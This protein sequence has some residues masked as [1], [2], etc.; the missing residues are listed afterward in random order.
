MNK[1]LFSIVTAAALSYL[2]PAAAQSTAVYKFPSTDPAVL[3]YAAPRSVVNVRITVE[4][5]S[6]RSGPYARY[7]QRMLG[8]TAPLTDRD[9]YTIRGV[10]LSA[11]GSTS[12]RTTGIA[13][14]GSPRAMIPIRCDTAFMALTPDR[15]QMGGKSQEEMARDAANAIFRLRKQRL[16][17]ISGEMGENVFGDGMRAA[18]A[19]IE[20]LEN[21]YTALFLGKRFTQTITKDYSV[22]PSADT[23]D[24][25]VAHFSEATGIAPASRQAGRPIVLNITTK[26]MGG[27]SSVSKGKATAAYRIA[28]M[29]G[30]RIMDGTTELA[31]ATLPLFQFGITVEAAN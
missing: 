5:Q 21:E 15:M 19:E 22:V 30:C 25:T 13:A 20:R 6:V 23:P 7:A 1:M 12:P 2:A 18:L 16:D 29:V 8:V 26:P 9:T 11:D 10:S 3:Q 14:N 24:Y 31:S 4:K 28:G 27:G 17:L